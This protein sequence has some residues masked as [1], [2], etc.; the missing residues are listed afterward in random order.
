MRV[1]L[2]QGM[3][4]KRPGNMILLMALGLIALL[5]VVA[6]SMDGGAMLSERRQAQA[7][8]DAAALAAAADLFQN[9]WTNL[10]NDPL[11]SAADSAR[12]VAADNGYDND[13]ITSS[14]MV[15]IPPKEGPFADTSGFVEVVVAYKY[16]RAF[17]AVFSGGPVTIRAR[18]VA[19]GKPVPADVGMLLLDKNARAALDGQGLGTTSMKGMPIIVNSSH[20]ESITINSGTVAGPAIWMSGGY[21]SSLLGILSGTVVAKQSTV[22]DPLRDLSPPNPNSLTLKTKY[23]YDQTKLL[24]PDELELQPGVY[25]GGI[26][27]SGNPKV[28]LKPGIYYMEDGGFSFSGSGSLNGEGVLIYASPSSSG[29]PENSLIQGAVTLSGP[30]S[31]PYQGIVFWQRRDAA[32]ETT[33]TGAGSSTQIAGTI[34][35]AGGLLKISNSNLLGTSSIGSQYI[36]QRLEVGGAGNITIDWQPDKV[37]R[38]RSIHL[39]E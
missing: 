37:A 35:A 5:G 39:V 11:E 30:T 9:Y 24:F 6:M 32:T 2:S 8:A 13:G 7:V 28:T 22:E 15:N 25:K 23:E 27:I 29:T 26:K 16:E 34:Y 12:S 21:N 3:V 19:M 4:S 18:A 38:K 10:G 31:G 36:T 33:V 1:T 17:S 20:Q 14:V